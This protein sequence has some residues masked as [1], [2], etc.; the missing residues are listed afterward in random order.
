MISPASPAWQQL[1]SDEHAEIA[2]LAA[3]L[4]ALKEGE[5]LTAIRKGTEALDK[6]TR[7]FAELMMDAA[8]T[9][10]IKGQTMQAAGSKLGE[11]PAAPH[12]IAEAEFH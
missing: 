8:V 11:G 3:E 2:R 4:L 7:R 9:S 6:A 12:P 10:A 1:T 5:D